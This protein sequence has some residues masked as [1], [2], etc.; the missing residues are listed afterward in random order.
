MS[1]QRESTPARSA[2]AQATP[3]EVP[4]WPLY[5]AVVG[6]GM[7]CAL[8]IVV[9]HELTRPII[10]RNRAEALEAAVLEVLPGAVRSAAFEA[11]GDGFAKSEGA[12]GA[13]PRVYA[14]YA[15]DGSLVG[16]AIA[17]EGTGYQDTIELLYGY[18]PGRQ[19]V[20][21]MVVLQSRE[22]PGLGDKIDTDPQFR[23]NFAALD[24]A[25]DETGR[26]LLH[27]VE[28]VASGAKTAAWQ[29]DA[30]TG[31]TISSKAVARIVG[32]SV[33]HWAPRIT[34]HVEEFQP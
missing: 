21:G 6:V 7:L 10:L 5:R 23:R 9:V 32:Q 24:V 11:R 19:A 2:A 31:A 18:A 34:A 26:A 15:A 14:G 28:T 25:L 29:V 3:A 33:A 1:D 16:V 13:G 30:I 12:A 22:T 8:L 20:V 27:P 17:A 4:A